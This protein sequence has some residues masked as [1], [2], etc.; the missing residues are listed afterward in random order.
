MF[1][2]AAG[3]PVFRKALCAGERLQRQS[4]CRCSTCW[5]ERQ[6]WSS[7]S[8]PF[9]WAWQA[10]LESLAKVPSLDVDFNGGRGLTRRRRHRTARQVPWQIC[11]HVAVQS[12]VSE[13]LLA[14]RLWANLC[15]HRCR[16]ICKQIAPVSDTFQSRN[17]VCQ[18][19][20]LRPGAAAAS[21]P[22]P[23]RS[24]EQP[25]DY[26]RDVVASTGHLCSPSFSR[27]GTCF[28]ERFVEDK[29]ESAPV[30]IMY[31]EQQV[32]GKRTWTRHAAGYDLLGACRVAR[33]MS[34]DVC[35]NGFAILSRDWDR[36]SFENFPLCSR[37]L[38]FPLPPWPRYPRTRWHPALRPSKV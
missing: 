33:V 26:P 21:L 2:N 17:V 7:A 3:F 16:R 29:L 28:D 14:R 1:A 31:G 36:G 5:A 34:G 32:A 27:G 24:A 4:H 35:Q 18:W 15:D 20:E 23:S 8:H 22:G 9:A 13:C 30:E 19:P 37:A 25:L 10:G 11:L 6:R 38:F 12:G